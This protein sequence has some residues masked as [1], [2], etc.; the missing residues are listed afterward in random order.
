MTVPA[1]KIAAIE[2]ALDSQAA[3]KALVRTHA[4]IAKAIGVS[5]ETVRAVAKGYKPKGGPSE[6]MLTTLKLKAEGSTNAE[7]A[8]RTGRNEHAVATMLRWA[9][10][11]GYL[12]PKESP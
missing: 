7:I 10:T 9:A 11:K 8:Q 2:A 3:L 5:H 6:L 12:A 1:N 4:Q